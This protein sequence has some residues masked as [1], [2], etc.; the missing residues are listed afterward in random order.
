MLQNLL[1][2]LDSL[3]SDSALQVDN[4]ELTVMHQAQHNM[5]LGVEFL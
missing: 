1:F 5:V 3:A 2:T 4:L